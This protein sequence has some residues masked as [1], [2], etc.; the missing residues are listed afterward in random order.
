MTKMS[1][2]KNLMLHTH[3]VMA[4]WLTQITW[5]TWKQL[6]LLL[7]SMLGAVTWKPLVQDISF[8]LLKSS[9]F[10]HSSFHLIT[11]F[12]L[13]TTI[14]QISHGLG[15]NNYW[16]MG[17]HSFELH[18]ARGGVL[19]F[20]CCTNI[21]SSAGYGRIGQ[22]VDIT[23]FLV[24]SLFFTC[25]QGARSSTGQT[26]KLLLVIVTRSLGLFFQQM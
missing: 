6:M 9:T 10:V 3:Q 17:M 4:V 14:T 20:G 23:L 7:L 11:Q 13:E 16:F 21:G 15:E 24:F 22:Q 12:A 5:R 8:V 2:K 1:K 26:W 18:N 25:L 19:N